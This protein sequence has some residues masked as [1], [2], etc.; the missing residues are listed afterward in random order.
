MRKLFTICWLILIL[1]G[2]SY[3]FWYNEWKYSLPTP[4]PQQYHTVN[5]G[6]HVDLSDK[7]RYEKGKPLLI[8]FFN[9]EC[10]CSRF[11]IPHFNSLVKKYSTKMNFAV[12]LI[13][14]KKEYSEKEIRDKYDL[15]VPILIDQSIAVSCGVYSTPL[16]TVKQRR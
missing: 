5:T 15:T 7:I 11:N 16:S 6:A 13:N 14:L 10:P 4:V 2:I 1:S 9:P 3:I 8:H 12:V